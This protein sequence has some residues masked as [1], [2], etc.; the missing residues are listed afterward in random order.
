[1]AC[2]SSHTICHC[3]FTQ[4]RCH[5]NQ[6]E[7]NTVSR[8]LLVKPITLGNVPART[9]YHELE[10]YANLFFILFLHIET[11]DM[12]EMNRATFGSHSS[13][14]WRW[15]HADNRVWAK[16]GAEHRP[17]WANSRLEESGKCEGRQSG[18]FL[19]PQSF[20]H[21]QE[22]VSNA[23]SSEDVQQS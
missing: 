12:R 9:G 11:V 21:T 13:V 17:S 1:M 10:Q 4:H 22:T 8:T 15:L 20:W 6:K 5:G 3:F 14:C 7:A 19:L 23:V 2:C 18:A 16:E